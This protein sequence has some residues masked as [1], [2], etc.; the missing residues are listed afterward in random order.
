[1]AV[2][3]T[4]ETLRHLRDR[5]AP[6]AQA[7]AAVGLVL[8]V[9]VWFIALTHIDDE[10][11]AAERAAIQNSANL[12]G[13]FD[14][15]LSRSLNEIDRSIKLIRTNY[16][17]DPAGF[18]FKQWLKINQLF[19]DQ[20]LQVS[21]ISRDGF[22]KLSSIDSPTSVGTDLRDREHFKFQAASTTDALF[23]SEPV[24]GRTTGKWSIQLTRRISAQ[25]GAFGGMVVVSLDP[26]YLA[27]FYGS[28]DLGSDGYVQVVGRDGIIRAMGGGKSSP[29]GKDLSGADLFRNFTEMAQ[30]GWYYTKS[31]FSDRI[32]RLVSFRSVNNYPL[33]I[34]VGLA[35]RDIFTGVEAKRRNY[36]VIALALTGL[37]IT[38]VLIS[39]RSRMTRARLATEREVQ[40]RRLDAVLSNMPLGICMIDGAGQ[41]ALSNERFRTMYALPETLLAPGATFRDL[42]RYRANAGT[43][44]G[45]PE[46]FCDEIT[47]KLNQGRPIKALTQLQDGR[48]FQV[49]RQ[50]MEGGGWVSIHEDVTQQHLSKEALEQTKRFLDTI[51]ENVP[52]PIVVK[53]AK[54]HTFVLVNKAYEAFFGLPRDRLI[55]RTVFEIYTADDAQRIAKWDQ[56]AINSGKSQV[57][58]DFDITTPG[59]GLRSVNTTRLVVTDAKGAAQ[60]VIA[61][62]EDITEKKR[63]N[64]EIAHMAHHDPLTDLPNRA[65]LGKKLD[66][67]LANLE[68]DAKLGVLF[69]DL[70][71]F[72]T[73][74]DTLGHLVGDELLREVATR[75]RSCVRESDT[76]ARLG[77]DEFAI[78]QVGVREATDTAGMAERVRAALTE[79]TTSEDCGR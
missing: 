53:D 21:I 58:A 8:I 18:D 77:G 1:M 62:I 41:L 59:S 79:S 6:F 74:N 61:V 42:V 78:I 31:N 30:S 64:A 22:I 43:F 47:D 9:A 5:L 73:V 39:A 56:A 14:E 15:H 3:I 70:D 50:P 10:R 19:D 28:V 55:N 76:V 68:E 25:D 54:S 24:I 26:A 17:N 65:M 49:L 69:L 75:L 34:T 52:I 23:I 20:T 13:A 38:V 37:I 16:E 72:K 40:N 32:P 48:F 11:V 63:V 66:Q 36:F 27:R 44:A 60:Y 4:N 71:H 67:A 2:Q 35:S 7:P 29:I 46:K 51:I 12:A 57:N 45:D 33:I